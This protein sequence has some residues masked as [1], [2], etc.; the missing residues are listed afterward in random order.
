[1]PLIMPLA[2]LVALL[3]VVSLVFILKG[4]K[5]YSWLEFHM[6]ARKAGFSFAEAGELANAAE[7]AGLADHTNLFWSPRDLD[8]VIAVLSGGTGEL[9]LGLRK[10]DGARRGT[11]LMEKIYGL[12]KKLELEQPRYLMGI[13]SSRQIGQGQRVRLLV[14]GLGVFD[15]TVVDNSARF[16]VLSY[17]IGVRPSGNFVWKGKRVSVYFWRK[18]DAGYVFDS[19]VLDDLRIRDVPVIHIAHSESLFRTQKRKSVRANVTLPA[20]LYLLK[21]IEGAFEKAEFEP[22]LRCRLVDLSEDGL[23]LVIGGK[24]RPGLHVK[25]QFMLGKRQIV[26]SGT[27]RSA[28]YDAEKNRSVIHVEAVPPSPRTRNALRSY[29]YSARASADQSP[30]EASERTTGVS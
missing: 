16:L 21:R 13:R 12:R 5:Q 19:Y 23:A 10:P 7:V 3:T 15:A 1:M 27:V 14:H 9:A 8:K 20:R 29:I 25:V 22:G 17:P 28:G 18:E 11:R 4:G 2:L 30:P 24:A 26:M 6:R